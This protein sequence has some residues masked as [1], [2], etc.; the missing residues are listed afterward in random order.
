MRASGAIAG[1]PKLTR[2]YSD[3][4]QGAEARLVRRRLA[5]VRQGPS[6]RRLRQPVAAAGQFGPR[7]TGVNARDGTTV[8]W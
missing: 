3:A 4:R 7:L 1:T 2:K 5:R 6:A 8:A